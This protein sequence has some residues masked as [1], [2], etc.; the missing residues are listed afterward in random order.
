MNLRNL[1]R[2]A[3]EWAGP[4]SF[5]NAV[6]SHRIP[7]RAERDSV[8]TVPEFQVQFYSWDGNP[9]GKLAAPSSRATLE[10]TP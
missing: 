6:S 2:I 7:T 1:H 10:D 3:R 4:R 5:R 9:F 8:P